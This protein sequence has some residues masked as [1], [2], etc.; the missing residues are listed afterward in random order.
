MYR[1]TQRTAVARRAANPRILPAHAVAAQRRQ[2]EA[3]STP[4]FAAFLAV[5]ILAR[6]IRAFAAAQAP[7]CLLFSKDRA[8]AHI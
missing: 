1:V 4:E 8:V 3:T 7:G 6:R 5:V 2:C